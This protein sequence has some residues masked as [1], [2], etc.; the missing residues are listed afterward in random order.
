LQSLESHYQWFIE[1]MGC[2]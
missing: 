1:C 2:L